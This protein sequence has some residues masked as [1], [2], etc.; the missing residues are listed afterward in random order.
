MKKNAL[1]DTFFEKKTVSKILQIMKLTFLLTVINVMAIMANGFSQTSK[2][3]LNLQNS[4]LKEVFS[5]IE[6]QTNFSFLFK[7]DAI[8][9]NQKV[10]LQV[11]RSNLDEVLTSLF[12]NRNI[13]Y[14]ILDNS[15]IVLL[16]TSNT[17]VLQQK[18]SGTVSDAL[19]GEAIIGA[20]VLIEGTTI[21]VVT[22]V[23]GKFSIEIPKPDAILLVSFLGYNPERVTVG[24]QSVLNVK[25][26]PNITKLDEVVVIGYGTARKIDI[27][28]ASGAIVTK[29]F[30]DQNVTRIDQALQGRVAGVQVENLGGAPGSDVKIRIRGNNSIN[31]NNDP[32][33]VVDGYVGADF[34]TLN[35]EDIEDIQVLKDASACAIYGNRGANGVVIVTTKHGKSGKMS[36]EFSS[37]FSTSAITKKLDVLSAGDYA[38]TVND[39][40]VALGSL[41][42]YTNQQVTDY[43]SGATAGTNWQDEIFRNGGMQEYQLTSSG[44]N[45][46]NTYYISGNYLTQN[47]IVKNSNYTRYTLRSNVTSKLNDKLSVRLN[48]NATYKKGLNNGTGYA[49]ATSPITQALSWSPTVPIIDPVTKDYVRTDPLSSI[50]SNPMGLVYRQKNLGTN[51]MINA[52]GGIKYAI[53]SGLTFDLSGAVDYNQNPYYGFNGPLANISGNVQA[54][55][56]FN[57]YTNLITTGN[58]NYIKKIGN[59]SLNLT[60][61]FEA[62]KNI[63][64]YNSFNY[65]NLA[66]DQ[67]EDYGMNFP[68]AGVTPTVSTGYQNSALQSILGRAVYSFMDKYSFTASIRRDGS[69]KFQGSNQWGTFPS[70]AASWRASEEPFIKNLNLFDNLKVRAS[71]GVTGNQV[72]GPYSTLASF[73]NWNATFGGS[74]LTGLTYNVIANDQ[75]KWETTRQINTGIDISLFQNRVS[76]S[77]DYFD[78]STSHELMSVQLPL[79]VGGEDVT[80]NI[81]KVSNKG[82][83]ISV[84]V[85]PIQ[86]KDFNWSSTINYTYVK[87]KVEALAGADTI[88]RSGGHTAGLL[89]G[90]EY[91]TI[92]GNS[93]SSFWGYEY[94][95]TWK[96]DE[97]AAAAL[98]G[99]VP[100]DAKYLD[101]NGDHQYNNKDNKVIGN[102][103]PKMSIGWNNTLTY[104]NLSLNIFIQGLLGFDKWN[105]TRAAGM[106]YGA[107]CKE[108]IFADIK[109][110]YIPGVNETS[111]IPAFSKTNHN[112]AQSSRF[113]EKGDFIRLKNISLSYELPK[114]VL[115][116]ISARIF[117][118]ST[119]LITITKYKGFDPESSS[120]GS[121]DD[122]VTGIDLGG[123]PNARTITGGF[124]I[125]F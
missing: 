10:D 16:P 108:P 23:N 59:H 93:L 106:T 71:W 42:Y 53:I 99:A 30:K 69:S 57:M 1:T 9:Q 20:N 96:P 63:N 98:Y 31:G 79:Y 5:A 113:V 82:V 66:T 33:F 29:D 78:K 116:V 68:A 17:L 109:D 7:T 39:L 110:R 14:Q 102:P 12:K 41:P 125:T 94:L 84:N 74:P 52:I 22:D 112:Y 37:K 54:S 75:L 115:K 46:K 24:G 44:G 4:S 119:N 120:Y 101:I 36:I 19:N 61:V 73:G 86:T 67:F 34:N 40:Q 18:L 26:V 87:N 6:N 13:K 35:T 11:S 72:V 32:L 43:K 114:S 60:A 90:N 62:S 80:K 27:S 3:T 70:F 55:R 77:A 56:S 15:L 88:Y 111:D 50:Y 117:V 28:G 123:Y 104:K 21:G 118:S 103:F 51:Y 124:T 122:K 105:L 107:T 38:Q 81:G 85:I 100:G 76:L 47:G 95:G 45:E 8:N 25:L 49:G 91:A 58:L 2:I 89:G 97:V 92:K 48:I 64:E 83:E 65:S 121:G